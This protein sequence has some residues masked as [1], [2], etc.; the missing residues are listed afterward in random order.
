MTSNECY[1]M[2]RDRNTRLQRISLRVLSESGR[3]RFF[4]PSPSLVYA[5]TISH[6][7]ICVLMRETIR[8]ECI[9]PILCYLRDV[10]MCVSLFV[11]QSCAFTYAFFI[12]LSLCCVFACLCVHLNLVLLTRLSTSAYIYLSVSLYCMYILLWFPSS[13]HVLLSQPVCKCI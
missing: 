10:I 2:R 11:N 12:S 9:Y 7:Y 3:Q 4:V 6:E 13:F 5:V 1:W 8:I